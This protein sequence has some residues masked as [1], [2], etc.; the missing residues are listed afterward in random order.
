[1]EGDPSTPGTLIFG[2]SA[3]PPHQGH[4]AMVAQS[5]AR[6]QARGYAL[7]RALLVPVYRR[8]PVGAAKERLPGTYHHRFVM[9]ALVARR[10]ARRLGM[11]G[12]SVGVSDV[13]ARLARNRVAPNVTAE[14]LALLKARSAPGSRL[15]FLISSELVSGVDPQFGRWH[16]PHAILRYASLA[17][18]PRPG[19]PLNARFVGALVRRGADVI[20]LPHVRTPAIS[21][22]TVRERLRAGASPL[23]LAY[24]GVLSLPVA[25]YLERHPI[26]RS[27]PPA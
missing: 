16:A 21:S 14:T 4:V 7:S 15:I 18:C 3:D 13:E 26:Y 19:Y 9:C 25:R 5:F 12:R 11:P 27:S 8:N 2:L 6:L 20:L 17:I 24:H 23:A 1:M 22:T 10:I